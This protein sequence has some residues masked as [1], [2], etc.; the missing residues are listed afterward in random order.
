MNIKVKAGLIVA[1]MLGLAIS[2]VVL[3]KLAL[4]YI[5]VELIPHIFM[6]AALSIAIYTLYS[7][8]LSRLEYNAKLE[9]IAKK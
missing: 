2:A 6:G 1:G 3:I 7:I 4:T 5:S 8:T 9:E